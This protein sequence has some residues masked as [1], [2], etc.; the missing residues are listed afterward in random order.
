[1][2]INIDLN[3][4]YQLI[5]LTPIRKNGAYEDFCARDFYDLYMLYNLYKDKIDFKILRD[6]I[7]KT[8]KYR[9]SFEIMNQYREIAELF[10]SS[11]IV[12]DLWDRYVSNNLYVEGIEFFE[13][14][15][16]YE[17]IGEIL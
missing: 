12:S 1:M 14:I 8:S 4:E 3:I 13:T 5:K 10:R 6:A 11:K 15:T 7:E 2:N 9:G 17:K 16:V